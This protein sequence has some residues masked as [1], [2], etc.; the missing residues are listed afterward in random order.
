MDTMDLIM[1]MLPFWFL[2]LFMIY[3]TVKSGNKNLLRFES[4]PFMKWVKLVCIMSIYRAV[5]F[6]F[7]RNH[8]WVHSQV[9]AVAFLPW[10]ASLTVFWE[11]M[12]FAVP[13]VLLKQL[14]D[15]DTHKLVLNDGAPTGF[16]SNLWHGKIKKLVYPAAL[17]VM[18]ASFASGHIYQGWYAALLLSLYVPI[19]RAKGLE[20]GFGT[21]IACHMLYD[22]STILAIKLVA[23]GM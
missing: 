20:F 17:V 6:Y 15:G 21:I 18:M 10:Q 4:K 11:D 2:G 8:P 12:S 19:S 7:F 22:L 14:L 9:Q 23:G 5:V 13:L 3:A 1:R 16:F